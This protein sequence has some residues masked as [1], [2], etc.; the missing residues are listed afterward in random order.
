MNLPKTAALRRPAGITLLGV[1]AVALVTLFGIGL[2]L[3][4]APAALLYLIIV[5]SVSRTGSFVPAAVV[6]AFAI[7][8]LNYVFIPR[9]GHGLLA[10]ALELAAFLLAALVITRLVERSAR[11]ARL[12]DERALLLDIA[13]DAVCITRRDD[14]LIYWSRGAEALY[15]WKAEEALGR[16]AHELLQTTSAQPIA[17]IAGEL[18]RTGSWQGELHNKTRDGTPVIVE[19]RSVVQRDAS[20][21]PVAF[22]VTANDITARKHAEQALR[23]AQTALHHATRVTTLG[24]VSA[25]LAHEL[26]QPLGAIVNN[27]HACLAL[28][29]GD[30]AE[31]EE[32][33][34]ALSDIAA[35]AEHGS[36][37][38]ERVRALATRVAPDLVEVRLA[39]VVRDVLALADAVAS[40]IV[41]HADVPDDLP[42][43]LGVRVQLQQV[44]LNFILNAIDAMRDV[45]SERRIRIVS[46]VEET[47][48]AGLAVVIRVEDRGIGLKPGE[49]DRLFEPY[50]TTKPHGMGLGL[51][52]C[53][54]IITAHGGRLWAESNPE[55]GAVFS[56]R[57][58]A[59]TRS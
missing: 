16:S 6:S 31:L 43:V 22:L 18:L 13:H 55:G 1:A 9:G 8:C 10:E 49:I 32:V 39:D 27:A 7:G 30:R 52:I 42:V 24:E 54:S 56:V 33:R 48:D 51:A 46:V 17:E 53:R 50:Y 11:A 2:H 36:A 58:R 25:N 41:I 3:G 21:A 44:L 12:A 4:S 45:E 5:V 14:R 19:S 38:I 28:L 15:G 37:V 40:G 26:N 34:E 20:G 29:P 47:E 57:L 35:A 23:E 59:R